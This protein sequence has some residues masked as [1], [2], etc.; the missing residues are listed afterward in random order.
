MKK[1]KKLKENKV[2]KNIKI[3]PDTLWGFYW[4]IIKQYKAYFIT[5]FIIGIIY[6]FLQLGIYPFVNKW[7]FSIFENAN[8][9]DSTVLYHYLFMIASVFV[10]ILLFTFLQDYIEG[11]KRPIITRS[12]G[13][14]LFK[15]IYNNDTDF[16]VNR[17]AGQI[18]GKVSEVQNNFMSLTLD[19]STKLFGFIISFFMIVGMLF[20]INWILA[21]I[22]LGN[23]IIR[24]VWQTYRQKPINK[25]QKQIVDVSS[26]ISGART[27]SLGNAITTRLFAKTDDENNYIWKKQQGEIKLRVKNAF[28]NRVRFMPTNFVSSVANIVLIILCYFLIRDGKMFISEA[29]FAVAGFNA[30]NGLFMR[31]N[32]VI[33]DYGE[34]KAKATH[35]YSDLIQEQKLSDAPNAKNLRIKKSEI[36]FENVSFDYGNKS[37]I[38]NF[39]LNV[40]SGEKIGIVGLSGAGKTT[41]VNLILRLYDVKQGAIKIDGQ[42]VRDVKQDSLRNQI[43]FVPQESVLFNRSLLENIKYA[44]RSATKAQVITA[45]KFAN[46]H[47]FIMG[48]PKGYNTLVGNRGIKLS[49]G[50]RQRIAIARAILKNAPILI[51][52]EATSALDSKN[53]LFIQGAFKKI[54]K[55]KTSI[56]IAHR[57]STL[58]NMDRIVVMSNG[59]IVELGSHNSLLR[60][61]GIYKKLWGMQTDGFIK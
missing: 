20:H 36:G 10:L 13:L 4:H 8:N 52:D 58:R 49:G 16:F 30:I 40:V 44:R 50:Q 3:F 28:L 9:S 33:K 21:V 6:W 19:L 45:C 57:L 11:H 61:S 42:D 39:G 53:E 55:G 12:L 7:I 38:K 24:T 18:T 32:Q 43:A 26:N 23:G 47:E 41:L 25:L 34:N 46:I 29:A 60:Q 31:L 54:M 1:N 51:L 27:D 56:V 35:A 37:V 15:R 17:P 5:M 2:K 48:L 22:I 14:S 59:K